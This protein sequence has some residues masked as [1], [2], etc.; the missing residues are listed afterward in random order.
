M[1]AELDFGL[2]GYLPPIEAGEA[3]TKIDAMPLRLTLPV[4]RVK[5]GNRRDLPAGETG[6]D[7]SKGL[8]C[9]MQIFRGWRFGL[10]PRCV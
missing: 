1:T 7:C 9:F 5:V 4:N 8:A 10:I 2:R 3:S 6:A